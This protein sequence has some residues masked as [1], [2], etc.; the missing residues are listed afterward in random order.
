MTWTLHAYGHINS[1]VNDDANEKAL[2]A[3]LAE[4]IKSLP[5]HDISSCHF[6][7][8]HVSGDLRTLDLT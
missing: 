7:G 2:A 5:E 6:A 8:N 3:V 1:T 4:A